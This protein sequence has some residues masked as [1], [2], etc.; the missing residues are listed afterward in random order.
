MQRCTVP[1]RRSEYLLQHLAAAAEWH[2]L[3][4]PC[5]PQRGASARLLLLLLRPLADRLQCG[6][7][8]GFLL[9]YVCCCCCGHVR[10]LLCCRHN[11]IVYQPVPQASAAVLLP[12]ISS[13]AAPGYV[14]SRVHTLRCSHAPTSLTFPHESI[15][16]AGGL[17][18]ISLWLLLHLC[19]CIC[20]P[21]LN[22]GANRR[23]ETRARVGMHAP[24]GGPCAGLRRGGPELCCS[25]LIKHY[26]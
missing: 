4:R 25:M 6:Q 8:P 24:Q 19:C 5:I 20:K 26:R 12:S 23:Q 3:P 15:H 18:C 14:P 16:V 13:V 1:S 11:S 17:C 2:A 9:T 21:R 22:S 10:L 7:R